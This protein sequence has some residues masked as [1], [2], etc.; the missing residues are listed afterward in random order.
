MPC[1][2]TAELIKGHHDL[3]RLWSLGANIP[4][5]E[6]VG[7]T[8]WVRA[9]ALHVATQS[10]P[11]LNKLYLRK[12]KRLIWLRHTLSSSAAGVSRLGEASWVVFTRQ[13]G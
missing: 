10:V 12:A 11:T 4:M 7:S 3:L 1:S 13:D 2:V 5:H 6:H 9:L 8:S